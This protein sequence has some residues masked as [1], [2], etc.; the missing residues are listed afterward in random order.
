M[1]FLVVPLLSFLAILPLWELHLNA[2][3]RGGAQLITRGNSEQ[4][5]LIPLGDAGLGGWSSGGVELPGFP[6]SAGAGVIWRPAAVP[7][8]T[9]ETLIAYGDNEGSIHLIDC[10]GNEVFGWPVN[11][12]TNIVTSITSV[13]L[14]EDGEFE[15]TYGTSDGLVHLLDL[16][17]SNIPGFPVDLQSQLQFQP[18]IIS[19]G[20]GNTNGIVCAT[21]NSRITILGWDGLDIPGW[22]NQ[23]GFPAGTIPISGDMNGDG[24]ADIVFATQDG[25]IHLYNLMG[26]EQDGWP[27]FMDA[28]PAPGSVAVGHV[29]PDH[30]FPQIAV[31]SIDSTVYLLNG[32]GSL[33][34]TWRWPNRTDSRPAQPIIS[35]TGGGPSIITTSSSGKI[36]AW[37]ASGRRIDGFPIASEG[38]IAFPP[39][40]GD[41]DGDGTM[42]L[43]VMVAGGRVLAYPIASHVSGKCMWPLPLGDQYNSGSYGSDFLPVLEVTGISGE[44]SGPLLISYSISCQEWTG[45]S[46]CYS[47]DAGYSWVETRNYTESPGSIIWNSHEDLPF[48]DQ[49][50]CLV[51]ITPY[52]AFG[53]GESGTTGLLHIDN[54]RPPEIL[55]ESPVKIDD[56]RYRLAYAV[57]DIEGDIIQLQAQ[58]STDGGVTWERMHLSGSSVE[59]EPWFYGEPVTWNAADDIGEMD[60][61]SI[62][63]R[64][65]AADS[66]PGPWF[67]IDGLQ[68]D[69]S[70]LP[71]AQILAPTA[72]TGGRVVIGVRLNDPELNTLDVSYHYSVDGGYEWFPATVIEGDQAGFEQ[73]EFD[74]S[75]ESEIDLPGFDGDQVRFQALPSH[76]DLGIAVP[77][78]PFH[79]DNNSQPSISFSS[80]SIYD[81]FR[82]VVPVRFSLAD[83]E[84]DDITLN[85]EYRLHGMEDSWHMA[86]GLVS[87]GPF[88]P[89]SYNSVLNWNSSVDLPNVSM[90]DL[91]IRL[92]AS[93][94]DS[95]R[96]LIIGPIT[97]E[98]ANIP[99]VIWAAVTEIADLNTYAGHVDI[100][101]GLGDR[102]GRV[103]SLIVHY[104]TDSGESWQQATISGNTR[105]L[106]PQSY[107]NVLIWQYS[108]DIIDLQGT[109]LLRITPTYQGGK[110]GRPRFIEQVFQ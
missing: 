18:T 35:Y 42:E 55:M 93:D 15:I 36:H 94:G 50:R 2:V 49:R 83:P 14:N 8:S 44:F 22:P 21:S 65:R 69:S 19:L 79:L 53:P 80:P 37:D 1:N 30:Q 9:G 100:T 92:V 71:S 91:D 90:L 32:D 60:A 13:D 41:M 28:R 54:N 82:G 76:T 108:T 110:L 24:Q 59:I 6:V 105:G 43:I 87:Q 67:Y 40:A 85:L 77:S 104:S 56:S 64:I 57:E 99:D 109:V 38:E 34:G 95:V 81:V 75:W 10:L 72:E 74:V 11:N 23:T 61:D 47:I 62:K 51:R 68:I 107:S 17:G 52:S 73:Y 86:R 96:S 84:S 46:V 98:N 4:I 58:Y 78:A 16:R 48:E 66:D 29:E 12:S 97:L 39:V 33:A 102:N 45:I 26:E 31:A 5:L 27:F 88:G 101:F 63:L 25:K 70:R 106:G 103:L 7:G 3:P 89:S 20:G